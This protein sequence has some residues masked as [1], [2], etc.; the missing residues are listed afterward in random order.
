MDI[1]QVREKICSYGL[2]ILLIV[3]IPVLIESLMRIPSL[4]WQPIM[5]LHIAIV[6]TIILTTIFRHRC[7]YNM[8]STVIVIAI[9]LVGTGEMLNFGIIGSGWLYLVHASIIGAIL[10]DT[11]KSVFIFF[12]SSLVIGFSLMVFKYEVVNIPVD[13]YAYSKEV[14]TWGY[15]YTDFLLIYC[16]IIA[17]FYFLNNGLLKLVK[18]LEHQN[19]TLEARVAARTKDLEIEMRKAETIARIDPLTRLNNRHA[20]FEY[21]EEVHHSA[22]ENKSN[23]CIIM[24]DM[25]CFKRIN[26]TYGHHVGDRT[27]VMVSG[28][29]KKSISKNDFSARMGG[30]EFIVL[31]PESTLDEAATVGEKLRKI[32]SEMSIDIE[33]NTIS[34]NASFG[35]TSRLPDN[36][37]LLEMIKYADK[38]LYCA[39]ESGRNQVVLCKDLK[40]NPSRHR[41]LT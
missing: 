27:L 19:L 9:F 20:F 26:D 41:T 12:L 2:V 17:A 5:F 22:V 33:T 6:S 31:L 24:I 7:S 16:T 21:A 15:Y 8:R 34:I 40:D 10:F 1:N 39:K 29:L 32:I 28:L 11:K 25:D 13:I 35:I 23:Y 18:K 37:S 30:E 36:L 14:T 38:A 4:G 3:S